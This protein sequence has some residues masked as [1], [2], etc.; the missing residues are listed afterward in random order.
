MTNANSD[1]VLTFRPA[2]DAQAQQIAGDERVL[3]R[4][5]PG[6]HLAFQPA[7]GDIFG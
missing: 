1:D 6:T 4:V 2:D 5:A 3:D 7:Q